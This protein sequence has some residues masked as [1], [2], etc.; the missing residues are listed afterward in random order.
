[1][2]FDLEVEKSERSPLAFFFSEQIQPG[3]LGI[4][5]RAA[6]ESISITHPPRARVFSASPENMLTGGRGDTGHVFLHTQPGKESI[7]GREIWG[8]QTLMQCT[9]KQ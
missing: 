2:I 9:N 6:V 1:M 8:E 7:H 5:P 4:S 3:P